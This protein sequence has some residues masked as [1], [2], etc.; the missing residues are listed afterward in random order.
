MEEKKLPWQTY[1]TPEFWEMKEA[2]EAIHGQPIL[3]GLEPLEPWACD[4][5]IDWPGNEAEGEAGD[6]ADCTDAELD[7]ELN[8]ML[9]MVFGEGEEEVAPAEDGAPVQ[10]EL[11]WDDPLDYCPVIPGPDDEEYAPVVPQMP[12]QEREY[13]AYLEACVSSHKD[14]CAEEGLRILAD[15]VQVSGDTWKTGLN[16]NDLIIGPTGAGK[17]RH[18]IKPNLLQQALPR[19]Q[20]APESFIIT[21]TKGNL[22]HEVGP[23][24]EDN[25]Y[26][27]STIDFT[28]LARSD[29]GYNP[30]A[31]VR[32]DPVTREANEQDVMRIATALC[33]PST[34]SDPYWD[35]SARS[36][37][38]AMIAYTLE[39]LPPDEQHLGTVHTLVTNAGSNATEEGYLEIVEK[40]PNC[41]F[42]NQF[43]A[44]RAVRDSEKTFSC[45]LGVAAQH[46]APFALSSAV[47][48][49]QKLWQVD[50]KSLGCFPQALFLTV[51]DTDRSMDRLVN[52]L[53]S[54]AIS[55]LCNYADTKCEGN[56]LRFPVRMYLDDFAASAVIPDFDNITSV[57]RSRGISVSIVLQS[58][59]QLSA[60]YGQD[61]ARTIINNCAHILYLGGHDLDTVNYIASLANCLPDRILKLPVGSAFLYT[62]GQG[63]QQVRRYPLDQHPLY[64]QLPEVKKAAEAAEAARREKELIPQMEQQIREIQ[65]KWGL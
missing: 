13:L 15:G 11:P 61:R 14:N 47:E 65:E 51:S 9:A 44:V 10:G 40:R 27:L 16:N 28:N 62:E 59:T 12:I 2:V 58:I 42:V 19:E 17:T 49:Y 22:R 7:A 18:Y 56:R 57:I 37:V 25:D 54:Q 48:F 45:I 5:V 52:L 43:S 21:D 34:G 39:W 31:F 26:E 20:N 3:E 4:P 1:G 6:G 53:Y 46:L 63:G 29:I 35:N 36:L 24:L 55:E 60:M 23:V 50:L 8:S 33:P 32:V 64:P 30:L 38:A 41:L